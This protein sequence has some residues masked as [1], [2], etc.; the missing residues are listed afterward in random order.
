M[1]ALERSSYQSSALRQPVEGRLRLKFAC[2]GRTNRTLLATC[3][4]QPPLRVV[5]AFQLSDGGTLVHLH[6]LSGGVLGGDRLETC[7][8][9]EGRARVQVTSTG[10]TRL[11]RC[12]KDA[13]VAAQVNEI[14]V[15]EDALLEY[16]PDAL[17]PFAGSRYDQQTRIELSTGAGLFW[18]EVVAPG[19]EARGETFAYQRLRFKLDIIAAGRPLAQE[20]FVLEPARQPLSSTIRLGPYRHFATFYICRVGLEAS[21]WLDLESELAELTQR[22]SQPG[23]TLWGVSTLPLHGLVVR[24]LS[25]NGR[26]INAG[27]LAF[28]RAAKLALYGEEAVPPRKVP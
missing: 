27:L 9:V 23:E 12:R 22:L 26:E 4:Q 1:S 13:P 3:E 28:W 14:V 19:R 2:A 21:R 16:L 7:V 8:E 6:N 20:R 25:R 5:R 24:A 10:A 18:W 17:I 11:Y 15:K